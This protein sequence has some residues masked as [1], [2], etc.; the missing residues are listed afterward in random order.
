MSRR[1]PPSLSRTWVCSST[2]M[3]CSRTAAFADS[4][5]QPA[6]IS[7]LTVLAL[8][9]AGWEHESAKAAV[10][11]QNMGVLEHTGLVSVQLQPPGVTV[12]PAGG[13]GPKAIAA[14]AAE[15]DDDP[16]GDLD[17]HSGALLVALAEL[18]GDV[19]RAW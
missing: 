10:L 19:A 11:E 12:A 3:F 5:S 9:N 8:I 1:K 4:C 6:L 18:A 16:W 13:V 14:R 15:A 2:P 7:A 17:E